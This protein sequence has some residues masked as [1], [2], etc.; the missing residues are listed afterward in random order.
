MK[1]ETARGAGCVNIV[2]NTFE[3]NLSIIRMFKFIDQY[4]GGL[5]HRLY[6]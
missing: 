3:V 4:G 5:E 1:K 6:G 2:G